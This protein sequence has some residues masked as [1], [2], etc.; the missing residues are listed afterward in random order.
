MTRLSLMLFAVL[1]THG[2]EF[3][4]GQ[5]ARAVLGQSSFFSRDPGIA[6]SAMTISRG[7]LNVADQSGLVS[8]FNLSAIP[9][10]AAELPQRG[11]DVCG[12]CGF[13]PVTTLSQAVAAG[14]STV[15]IFGNRLAAI[16]T[17][18][19]QILI[20]RDL[21]ASGSSSGPDVVLNLS[22]AGVLSASESTIVD[23]I[24]IAL[25]A[26]RLFVGDGA[27]HRVLVW[28]T[29]PD[30]P[31]QPADSVIG[32]PDFSSRE[33]SDTPR[34]NTIWRPNALVSDGTNLFVG[35]SHDRR[36]LV[37]SAADA[38]LPADSILNSATLTGGAFAPGTLVTIKASK[39]TS[40]QFSAADDRLSALA[41]KLGGT[42]VFLNGVALP[43][44]S[45]SPVE[46]QL[47]LPYTGVASGFGSI[48]VRAGNPDGS[49]T[50]SSAASIAFSSASPGIYAF[51]GS[52][53]RPGIVLHQMEQGEGG[54]PVTQEAPA[55]SGEIITLWVTG[56]H[57]LAN[58]SEQMPIAGFPS[59]AGNDIAFTP[60]HALV[61]GQPAEI[62][63]AAL[64]VS[65]IGIY[66]VQVALPSWS[67]HERAELSLSEDGFSSNTITF[68][69]QNP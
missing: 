50:T 41:T 16:D 25:D 3:F 43:L 40:A 42:E 10:A 2:A 62:V 33:T 23:P 64:P 39:L 66:Q 24:S 5:A 15:S 45:V 6:V 44:L 59:S 17:R 14:S 9:A 68:A 1:T 7:R 67:N 63:S 65:S 55:V 53:P 29:L 31:N 12:L 19:H 32:Q 18:T 49:A 69:S 38:V 22:D 35:D 60:I 13:T 4:N 34:A 58:T 52:E 37:F 20:W 21:T 27:L 57:A 26:S 56:L 11:S 8:V 36:V 47:Q 61:N 51:A 28:K 48:Y 30:T 46:I 54:A